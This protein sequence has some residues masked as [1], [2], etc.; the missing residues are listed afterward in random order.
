MMRASVLL[1][2]ASGTMSHVKA[3]NEAHRLV[4]ALYLNQILEVT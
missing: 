4:T 1:L 2:R 3:I